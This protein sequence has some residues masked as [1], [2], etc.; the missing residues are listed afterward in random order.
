M[1]NY[2]INLTIISNTTTSPQVISYTLNATSSQCIAPISEDLDD[3]QIFCH[4]VNVS[5]IASNSLGSSKQETET[6]IIRGKY[7]LIMIIVLARVNNII[8]LQI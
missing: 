8:I 5:V 3:Q 2:N 6:V 1:E 7:I 4:P